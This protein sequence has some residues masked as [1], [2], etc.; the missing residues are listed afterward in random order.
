[1]A[2]PLNDLFVSDEIDIEGAD[3]DITE[4]TADRTSN[5]LS[6]EEVGLWKPDFQAT[7][8]GSKLTKFWFY[9]SECFKF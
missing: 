4:L 2:F 7:I 3:S 6:C 8:G 5:F 1:M 9:H